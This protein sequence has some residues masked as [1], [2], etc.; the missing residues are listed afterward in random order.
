MDYSIKK[1]Q[2]VDKK[3]VSSNVDNNKILSKKFDNSDEI[4]KVDFNEKILEATRVNIDF[5][6]ISKDSITDIVYEKR[7][8]VLLLKIKTNLNQEFIFNGD[9]KN[10]LDILDDNGNSIVKNLDMFSD[11]ASYYGLYGGNQ[12]D[13]I[14]NTNLYL[15]DITINRIIKKY[16][17]SDDYSYVDL[18]LLFL[19]MC[20]V[21][22]GYISI[23]NSIFQGTLN[24]T[25]DEFYNKF[26]FDRY[27]VRITFDGTYVKS[28]NYNCMFL[29][30]F[31]YYNQ[32][33]CDDFSSIKSLYGDV[34]ELG[35][36]KFSLVENTGVGGIG[37]DQDLEVLK[38]F[39]ETK[40][41][42]ILWDDIKT[43]ELLFKDKKNNKFYR[44]FS[45]KNLATIKYSLKKGYIVLVSATDF[46]LYYKDDINNNGKI[47]DVAGDNLGTH[48][49]IVTGVTDEGYLIVSSWGNEYLL[50][51]EN[52]LPFF[53]NEDTNSVLFVSVINYQDSS[54][55]R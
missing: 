4:E 46:T 50:K 25:D 6:G 18:Q 30:Y 28:F 49:M 12:S 5:Y 38:S 36:N 14:N 52:A 43:R 15:N 37:T 22:C 17:P 27:V 19:K 35:E 16:F 51:P 24:L 53:W 7:D 47:D 20:N 44:P 11:E 40:D 55:N 41:I 1:L 21:G 23:T 54:A 2:I 26:G 9:T 48:G 32:V 8:N 39:L 45:A 31:M 10:L 33:N 29:D 42:H 34:M 13:L 3:N